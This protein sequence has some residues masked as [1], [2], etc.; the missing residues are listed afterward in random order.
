MT[1][2]RVRVCVY[3]QTMTTTNTTN[4]IAEL[5]ALLPANLVERYP[6]AE[7]RIHWIRTNYGVTLAMAFK[8]NKLITAI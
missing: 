1:R 2:C 3:T 6:N 7:Q 5:A 4:D 8:A